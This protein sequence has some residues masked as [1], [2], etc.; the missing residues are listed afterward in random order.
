[1]LYGKIGGEAYHSSS[2]LSDGDDESE[3][4]EYKWVKELQGLDKPNS[5]EH[6]FALFC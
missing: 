2:S 6:V 4:E 5:G 3:E 1:M